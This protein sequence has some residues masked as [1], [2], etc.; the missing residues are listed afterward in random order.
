MAGIVSDKMAKSSTLF[1]I[2]LSQSGLMFLCYFIMD[3][4]P[5][6]T[7]I[8]LIATFIGFNYGA[9]LSLFPS[10]TKG[11]WGLKNFGMNYGILMSAWGLGGFFFSR[12]AQSLLA[13]TGSNNTSFLIAGSSLGFCLYLTVVLLEIKEMN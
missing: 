1:I 2:L 8:V 11:F 9:N 10:F 4:N 12:L 13:S 5:S 7:I 6:A 3:T